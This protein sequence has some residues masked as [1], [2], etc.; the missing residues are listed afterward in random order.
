MRRRGL[1]DVLHY[2]IPENEQE[3]ARQRAS[4]QARSK[5]AEPGC[6][7][8]VSSPERPLAGA[9]AAELAATW[10]SRGAS[11]RILAPFSPPPFLPR[12][13]GLHWQLL[14]GDA[15]KADL[16]RAV[17]LARDQVASHTL[18]LWPPE[19]LGQ[20]IQAVPT[21]LLRAL[22]V[23]VDAAQWGLEP[24]LGLLRQLGRLPAGLRVGAILAGAAPS[25]PGRALFRTLA[26]AARRQLGLRLELLGEISRDATSFR[27]LL[28]GVA[29]VE[30][31]ASAASSRS[32]RDLC[33]RLEAPA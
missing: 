6:W 9:L 25:E 19:S 1:E 4:E 22:I 13:E 33:L 17:A 20:A 11:A 30:L 16:A 12:V 23:P 8:L 21:G 32:M 5:T 24:A 31:D 29:A 27:S 14:D 2:F 18:I 26:S 15:A 3:E 10:L 7:C 28:S